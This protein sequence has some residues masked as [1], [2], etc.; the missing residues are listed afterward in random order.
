ME[1]I[2]K[3]KSILWNLGAFRVAGRQPTQVPWLGSRVRSRSLSPSPSVPPDGA[4][5]SPGADLSERC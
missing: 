2:A 5:C 1:G 3:A 4:N